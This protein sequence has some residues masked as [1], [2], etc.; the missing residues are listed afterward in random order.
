MTTFGEVRVSALGALRAAAWDQDGY[1]LYCVM[2]DRHEGLHVGVYCNAL[3]HI[4]ALSELLDYARWCDEHD[5]RDAR[6]DSDEAER[7]FRYYTTVFLL[8]EECHQD[9]IDIA[10][11]ADLEQSGPLNRLTGF[12]NRVLKHRRSHDHGVVGGFHVSNH[13]G[14]YYFADDPEHAIALPAA[15]TSIN[16]YGALKSGVATA[17][18]VPSM[19]DAARALAQ[20]VAVAAADTS[21]PAALAQIEAEYG[22]QVPTATS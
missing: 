17:L 21:T 12:V 15:Y 3:S 1:P 6:G 10:A 11:T 19:V 4:E 8:I 5:M 18:L 22:R 7:L 14:P 16:N 2:Q 20:A 9:L 13:H